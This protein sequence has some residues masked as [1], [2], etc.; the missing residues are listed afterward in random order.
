[1][2]AL[3]V[4]RIKEG[5]AVTVLFANAERITGTVLYTPIATGDSWI[6]ETADRIYHVQT[7]E[8]LFKDKQ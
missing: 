1:M 2:S 8:C 7:F 5:D 3:P 6:I 4:S